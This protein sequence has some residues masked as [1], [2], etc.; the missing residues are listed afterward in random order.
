M[1]V[2]PLKVSCFGQFGV[3]KGTHFASEARADP[4]GGRAGDSSPLILG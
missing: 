1:H 3:E 2:L 4:G